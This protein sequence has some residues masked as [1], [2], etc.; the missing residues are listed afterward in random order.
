MIK[1]SFMKKERIRR[2]K[3]SQVKYL[4]D[5]GIYKKKKILDRKSSSPGKMAKVP[6]HQ[7]MVTTG[8]KVTKS[9]TDMVDDNVSVKNLDMRYNI[10]ATNPKKRLAKLCNRTGSLYDIRYPIQ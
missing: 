8:P 1:D 5:L 4:G 2:L 7:V 3:E 6:V 10:T 9:R